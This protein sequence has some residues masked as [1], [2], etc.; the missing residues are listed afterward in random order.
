[1]LSRIPIEWFSGLSAREVGRPHSYSF[2]SRAAIKGS[3][4]A[5]WRRAGLG[6]HGGY[7]ATP[8]KRL[9]LALTRAAVM[10]ADN[11]STGHAF[12]VL[13]SKNGD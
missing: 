3:D 5:V 6:L 8:L 13:L 7:P 9:A 11:T 10:T 12:V 2:K 1:M 4:C